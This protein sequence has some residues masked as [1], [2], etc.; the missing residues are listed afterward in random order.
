MWG[1]IFGLS[2]VFHCSVCLSLKFFVE[3]WLIWVFYS[4]NSGN[5]SLLKDYFYYF[6]LLLLLVA[7]IHLY[8]DFSTPFFS[9]YSLCVVCEVSLPVSLQSAFDLTD[10]PKL[11]DPKKN[12]HFFLNL[13]I[14]AVGEAAE[15]NLETKG[16]ICCGPSGHHHSKPNAQPPNF[17]GQILTVHTGTASLSRNSGTARL[18][19]G[20][21]FARSL[22]QLS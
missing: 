20:E 22:T 16:N 17:G 4:A 19:N 8:N 5:K 9:I 11:L 10:F 13:L 3:N 14:A 21:W 18:R 2:H 12:V 15:G 7:V 6:L 1:F